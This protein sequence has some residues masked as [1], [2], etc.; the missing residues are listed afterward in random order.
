MKCL[1]KITPYDTL[2]WS[3]LLRF[4]LF[5]LYTFKSPHDALLTQS[6]NKKKTCL[7][8][9]MFAFYNEVETALD[10]LY[11]LNLTF[12]NLSLPVYPVWFK[13]PSFVIVWQVS[14]WCYLHTIFTFDQSGKSFNCLENLLQLFK[15]INSYLFFML[16]SVLKRS[17]SH[18]NT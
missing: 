3:K 2:L 18:K 6:R 8:L 11:T 14:L 10:Y 7:G 12:Y 9:L 1:T 4:S 13:P 16:P 17:T 15:K 5:L